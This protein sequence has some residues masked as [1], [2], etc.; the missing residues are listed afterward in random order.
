VWDVV[1]GQETLT[2]K[3][4]SGHVAGVTF[5]PDGSRLA[6][7]SWDGSVRVWNAETGQVVRTLRKNGPAAQFHSVAFSPDGQRLASLD[8]AGMVV[9]WDAATGQEQLTLKGFTTKHRSSIAFS[10]D[11]N[12]LASVS[13]DETVALWDTHTG[14]RTLPLQ[15]EVQNPNDHVLSVAFSPDGK[16]LAWGGP[17]TTICDVASGKRIH[18][19]RSRRIFEPRY[20]ELRKLF[21]DDTLLVWGVAFS[22]DGKRIASAT[23]PDRKVTIWDTETAQKTLTLY[24]QSGEFLAFS[25][26]GKRLATNGLDKTVKVWDSTTGLE[27]LTL[28]GHVDGV[29]SVAFSPDG[30]RLA[31]GSA[32]GTVKVWDARPLD[33]EPAKPSP[34]SR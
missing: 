32:D 1:A 7:A 10:P 29:L 30:N 5:S 33:A 25:P 6:S 26:D 21:K 17:G 3:G 15:V 19:L 23:I 11:C 13:T 24:G 4:H 14:E 22:P 34:T 2:L 8:S 28:T 31:S 18:T 9:M 20:E 12:R 27:T 16:H